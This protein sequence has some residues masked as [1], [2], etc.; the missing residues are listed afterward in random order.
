MAHKMRDALARRGIPAGRVSNKRPFDT[1]STE[2]QYLVGYE[3]EAERIRSAM[4]AD[5]VMT[6]VPAIAGNQDVRLVLGKD[7][8]SYAALMGDAT[9]IAYNDRQTLKH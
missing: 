3:N 5:V 6:A 1:Q 8:G 7:A 2:I 9:Q 4:G